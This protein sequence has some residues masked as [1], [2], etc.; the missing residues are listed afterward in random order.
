M[1]VALLLLLAL[2]ATP[3]AAPVITRYTGM[4]HA[5]GAD[6]ILYR[7]VHYRYGPQDDRHELVLYLCPGG[8]AFARKT[9]AYGSDPQAPD[10]ALTDARTGYREGVRTQGGQRTV[11]VRNAGASDT[12]SA[13]LPATGTAVIDGGFDAYVRAHWDV[14]AAGHTLHMHFLVPSRLRYLRFRIVPQDVHGAQHPRVLHLRLELD[15]WFAFALPH[16]DVTYARDTRQLLQYRGLS[17]IRDRKGR[18]I[19]VVIRFPTA[20]RDTKTDA[21]T[22]EKARQAPLDGRCRLD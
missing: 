6:S 3:T 10:F 16:I 21:A 7:E 5:R 8:K 12:R 22:L 13:R 19:N 17:N 11:Y 20:M 4:A 18:N 2:Q 1:S 15:R 14:L 9:L